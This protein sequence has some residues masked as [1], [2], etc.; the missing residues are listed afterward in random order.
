MLSKLSSKHKENTRCQNTADI[1][2]VTLRSVRVIILG[3]KVLNS[4]QFDCVCSLNYGISKG[5]VQYHVVV[6]AL[7]ILAIF[8]N[9]LVK[10]TI[11]KKTLKN[12]KYVS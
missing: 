1:L 12:V 2:H 10:S 7:S 11:F 3:K 9:Y 6:S 5:K 8:L 4:K